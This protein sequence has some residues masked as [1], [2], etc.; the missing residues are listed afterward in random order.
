M[1]FEPNYMGYDGFVWWIGVVEDRMDPLK[2]GRCRVRIAGAHTPDKSLIPTED[3]P[4]AHPM[5]PLTDS[6]MLMYKEGDYVVGFYLDGPNAQHPV[7]MGILPGIPDQKLPTEQGFS[8][9]RTPAALTSAPRPPKELKFDGSPGESI[10]VIETASAERNPIV[11]NEPTVSRLT[12]NDQLPPI[13]DAKRNLA[14]TGIPTAGGGTFD[15]PT[16]AYAAKYPYNRVIESESGHVIEID[17]T[18]TKERI[19]IYH[20]SGTSIEIN[21][22]G[23]HISRVNADRCDITL[24]DHNIF[25]GGNCNLTVNR[26]VNMKSGADINLEA[27]N[28][29]NIKA[30]KGINVQSGTSLSLQSQGPAILQAQNSL[31]LFAS[32]A[33]ILQGSSAQIQPGSSA[34]ISGKLL[35]ELGEPITLNSGI[36]SISGTA[37]APITPPEPMPTTIDMTDPGNQALAARPGAKVDTEHP[38]DQITPPVETPTNLPVPTVISQAPANT[39]SKVIATG[40]ILV[41]AMNRAKLQD[42]IQ[43]AA[44]WAQCVVESGEKF[45]AKVE[46]CIYSRD[47]LLKL[48]KSYFNESNVDR[49]VPKKIGDQGQAWTSR[50]YGGMRLGN[51]DEASGDGWKYRGRGIIQLTGKANYLA[52]SKAFNQDFVNY[53]DA[54][55]DPD[56]SADVAV[57]YFIGKAP[58]KK[59]PYAGDYANV[60][61]VTRYVNGCKDQTQCMLIAHLDRR[62]QYF[63][64]AKTKPEV[65]TYNPD[66][67]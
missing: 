7:M 36:A 11:L 19:H 17:D 59:G 28:S 2:L 24:S 35:G 4:W 40:D 57:W 5:M 47:N 41:R 3:L 51:G 8:D 20:R 66:L 18:P 30:G 43:R 37:P 12:R 33:A 39:V 25:V 46:N 38:V 16:S 60:L 53:P 34:P 44:I 61:S 52:A 54:M 62:A 9:P 67:V 42:P 27:Q 64:E 65:I 58:Q 29:V 63:E 15:E 13:I 49:Y 48:F 45:Q 55:L 31:T 26:N 23:T 50:A 1:N 32:G 14:L 10:S 6:S 56:L 22:D 21:P